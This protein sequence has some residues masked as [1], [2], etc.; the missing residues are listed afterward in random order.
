MAEAMGLRR[1]LKEYK[2]LEDNPDL[3]QNVIMSHDPENPY[4]CNFLIFGLE[5]E[6]FKGGFYH[7]RLT[8]P[9]TYPHAPPAIRLF[10]PNGWFHTNKDICLSISSFHPEE[11]NPGIK[12]Y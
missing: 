12:L 4:V 10:T 6:K 3:C 8:I 5:H 1:L 2:D 7:G 11:W 9:W